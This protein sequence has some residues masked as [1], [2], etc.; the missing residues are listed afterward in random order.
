MS[1]SPERMSSYRRQFEGTLASSSM[2]QVRVS[3]P[4]PTRKDTRYRSASLSKRAG[5]MGR[6]ATS[7]KSR[8]SSSANL[9]ALCY[10]MSM[11]F[12]PKLDLDAAAAENQAFMQTRTSERKEMVALNDRLAV[13]IEKVRTLESQ[14]KLLEAEIEALRNRYARPSGLRQLYETQL[15]DLNREAEQMRVQRGLAL[16]GKEA[17]LGQ[18]E[19]LK[20]KYAEAVEARKQTELEIEALRPDVDRATSARIALEKQQENLELE[21]MFLQRVHKEEIEELMQQIYTTVAKVDLSF[22]LPDLATALRDIQSQYDS[23]AAKNLQE[24]DAWYRNKFQDLTNASNKH[25][26]S[27][28]SVREEIASYKKDIV[29]KERELETLKTKNEFLESQIRDMSLRYKKQ[30]EDLQERI[31]A[32]NVDLRVTKEKIA[33]LLREY[34]DLL[35]IKMSLEIEITTYRKLIEGEDSRLS[36][37]VHNLSLN[38]KLP[39]TSGTTSAKCSPPPTT[40]DKGGSNKPAV[41]VIE[42]TRHVEVSSSD[43]QTDLL[44]QATELSERKTVLIRTVKT[45]EDTIESDTQERTILI[46]GAADDTDEE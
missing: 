44:D 26:Q 29:N 34:Q 2:Y 5:S 20:S 6:R 11:G 36:T 39:I 14:N 23:I 31:D 45:D 3:S 7:S 28:R 37:M 42:K 32:V 13:Y 19:S 17:M 25:A 27:V 22:G 8:M 40:T 12:G 21:L 41:T 38:G 1:R 30:E 10:G 15:K 46:S 18:L 33:L 4:S 43:T 35:N 16:A 24:M 9:E